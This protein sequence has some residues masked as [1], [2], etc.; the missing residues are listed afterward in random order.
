MI[1][2][3]LFALMAEKK[4][5]DIFIT[6]G[7][8][9]HIKI[10]GNTLPINQQAMDPTMIHRMAYEMMTPEQIDRFEKL[11]EMNL[12]FGRRDMGNFRINIFWQRNS[13]AIVVR[14]ILG[15]IP[16]LETLG[17]PPV[18][19]EVIMEKRGLVLVV[20][21]TGSGKSTTIASMLDHRNENRSGHILT[22][23]DPIEYLFKHK[24]SIVNQREIGADTLDWQNALRSAMRQ[25]PDC[26]LIG[27][28]RDR[29]TMGA[30]LAY[31][32]TGHLCLATLHANNAYHALNRIFSF[33]PMDGRAL[34]SLDLAAT[35]KCIASQR[36]IKR[37]DGGRI[38]TVEILLNT[39]QVG[40]LIERGEISA[41]REAME[42]SLAQGSRTFEQDLFRLF[43]DKVITLEEALANAD[44]PT[45]LSW[46]INN[47]QFG[48][49]GNEKSSR[50]PSTIDFEQTEPDGAS[51]REFTL[52]LDDD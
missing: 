18:L 12:S 37:P 11:K 43:K 1:I 24:M 14:Y 22:I 17:L 29:E 2:D 8:P 40:E 36:L 21:A 13:I 51:F 19:S 9:I 28:I 10:D 27:E 52:E 34:L 47:A 31:A 5:S 4:A 15:E 42:Q 3:K 23:E 16:R 50:P 41:I 7:T 38:P 49:G 35:L 39:R 26:I 25:A 32:Q 30:A 33:F 48:N 45:N 20:G 46:L 44:S 6:V